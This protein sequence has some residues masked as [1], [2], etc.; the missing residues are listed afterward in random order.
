VNEATSAG[1]DP[2][3]E[4]FD[5]NGRGQRC[6]AVSRAVGPAAIGPRAERGKAMAMKRF[7]IETAVELVGGFQ[8]LL[9]QQERNEFHKFVSDT[10]QWRELVAARTDVD[11]LRCVVCGGALDREAELRG[12]VER[13]RLATDSL[14]AVSEAWYAGLLA[15]QEQ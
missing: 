3:A 12:A 1:A 9:T 7:D 2:L 4:A 5:P 13:H 10:P 11:V 15:H 8:A 14:Y 6:S